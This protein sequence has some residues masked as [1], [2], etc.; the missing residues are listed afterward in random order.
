MLILSLGS[1]ILVKISTFTTLLI[2]NKQN[3]FNFKSG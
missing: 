1:T 2:W 3:M